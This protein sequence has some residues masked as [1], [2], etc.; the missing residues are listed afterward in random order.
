M[1]EY[2]V[3]DNEKQ[4]LYTMLSLHNILNVYEEY[5]CIHESLNEDTTF[6]SAEAWFAPNFFKSG[7]FRYE[8][9]KEWAQEYLTNIRT[10]L[11]TV[12]K[13]VLI[14]GLIM[15]IIG[16]LT[17]LFTIFAFVPA[18]S[19]WEENILSFD[20]VIAG[21]GS[22]VVPI[23]FISLVISIPLLI[24]GINS[25]A[26]LKKR[27]KAF[28]CEANRINNYL[29]D[30]QK[31]FDFDYVEKMVNQQK[32]ERPKIQQQLQS[33]YNEYAIPRA[34]QNQENIQQ[35][36]FLS[37]NSNLK[38]SSIND[39]IQFIARNNLIKPVT[40]H[41]QIAKRNL[42]RYIHLESPYY[43]KQKES[44]RNR[45]KIAGKIL[46]EFLK[47]APES[48]RES[49]SYSNFYEQS[50]MVENNTANE[51]D[52]SKSSYLFVDGK[53]NLCESGSLFY[54]SKGNLCGPDSLFYD[55]KGNLCG[56]DSLFY[57]SK[58]FLC[59]PDSTFYD[60]AGNYINPK[61]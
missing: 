19:R 21:I 48:K 46:E 29:Q 54:D 30:I 57:D 42:S 41:K 39:I 16:V 43:H 60:A 51:N 38:K 28:T 11:T 33:L 32:N 52:N 45:K 8:K 34:L 50:Q 56:P 58:G 3:K 55:S 14:I 13:S 53:G 12:K 4:A 20:T 15:F 26:T 61:A 24:I 18:A 25:I 23:G 36:L 59:G 7:K 31:R 35:I 44:A 6:I 17:V 10:P 47:N 22:V 27:K 2:T 5:N 40:E 1:G 9:E 37:N 49:S